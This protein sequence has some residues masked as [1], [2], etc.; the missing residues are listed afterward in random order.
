MLRFIADLLSFEVILSTF[1]YISCYGLS[2]VSDVVLARLCEFQYI[3][4]YGLSPGGSQRSKRHN[5]F[6]YISC[7]GLSSQQMQ[8]PNPARNFN[9][10]HVTVYLR[11]NFDFCIQYHISIHLMLRFIFCWGKCL[12][13]P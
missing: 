3:S 10:S 7:Y 12:S 13:M 1:Q 4:C 2:A 5:R 11:R 8:E 6:Q 9:T